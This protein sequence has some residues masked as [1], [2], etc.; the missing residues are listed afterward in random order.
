M[1]KFN[2]TVD[3]GHSAEV[4]LDI[5]GNSFSG[6]VVSPDYGTGHIKEGTVDNGELKGKVD[7]AG[8]TADFYASVSGINISGHLKYGWFFNKSFTGTML[9]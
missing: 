3:G 4:S 1:K 6:T 5:Q 7:L 9:A 8:Y 2:V